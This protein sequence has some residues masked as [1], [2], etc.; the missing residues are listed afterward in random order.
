MQIIHS[1]KDIT[2]HPGSEGSV[3]IRFKERI[4]ELWSPWGGQRICRLL[5]GQLAPDREILNFAFGDHPAF[6]AWRDSFPPEVFGL[7]KTFPMNEV[8][9]LELANQNP[10]AILRHARF[11]P[12]IIVKL[13]EELHRPHGISL[14]EIARIA[15]LPMARIFRQIDSPGS[16]AA[17]RIVDKW[18]P[19]MRRI[20]T[21]NSLYL[22]SLNRRKLQIASHYSGTLNYNVLNCLSLPENVVSDELLHLA[23]TC[24]D[25]ESVYCAVREMLSD[26]GNWPFS[27]LPKSYPRFLA[28]IE[29]QYDRQFRDE[30][31]PPPILPAPG[32]ASAVET[33]RELRQVALRF[34]NCLFAHLDDLRSG[35]TSAYYAEPPDPHLV[36]VIHEEEAGN[37]RMGQVAGPNNQC[38]EPGAW[39]AVIDWFQKGGVA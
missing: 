39:E 33:P 34:Q 15:A 35:I 21:V 26:L 8:F 12:G 31:F 29:R 7:A 9:F 22:N 32:W 5:S 30:L 38:P 25:G 27:T 1:N 24:S 2:I 14:T 6:E 10:V 37:R 4:R 11:R 20:D 19:E 23:A 17:V 13:C 3:E 36:W 16:R 28:A 18:P